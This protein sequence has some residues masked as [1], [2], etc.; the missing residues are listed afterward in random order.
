VSTLPI[1][2]ALRLCVRLIDWRTF[3]QNIN[4]FIPV[5]RCTIY[6]VLN[7]Q[8]CFQTGNYVVVSFL[9]IKN[10]LAIVTI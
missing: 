9:K 5:I 3:D 1:F 10:Q 2:A 6:A 7:L 8:A 4:P